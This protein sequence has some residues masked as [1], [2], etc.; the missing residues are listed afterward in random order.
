MEIRFKALHYLLASKLLLP[1]QQLHPQLSLL[2]TMEFRFVQPVGCQHYH[3][4][5]PQLLHQTVLTSIFKDL[6]QIMKVSLQVVHL[7]LNSCNNGLVEP[8][9]SFTSQSLQV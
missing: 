9:V 7:I 3:L 2:F 5:Q 4:Q 6:V 8:M 1:L